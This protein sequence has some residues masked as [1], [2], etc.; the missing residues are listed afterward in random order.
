MIPIG[1]GMCY[2]R[3][4]C[5]S[6]DLEESGVDQGGTGS[7]HK[8]HEKMSGLIWARLSI[9]KHRICFSARSLRKQ[10]DITQEPK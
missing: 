6:G 8:K 10:R 3:G 7:K 9:S 1:V 2:L 5:R 4:A